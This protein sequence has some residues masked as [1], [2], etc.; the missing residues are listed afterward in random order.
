M[1]VKYGQWLQINILVNRYTG[2]QS[3]NRWAF[4]S[5]CILAFVK[6]NF[7]RKLTITF[8]IAARSSY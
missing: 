2:G 4:V 3:V 1:T 5:T 7:E 8:C 6:I